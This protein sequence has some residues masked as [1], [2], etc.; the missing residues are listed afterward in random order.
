MTPPIFLE[1]YLMKV[2]FTRYYF[3]YKVQFVSEMMIIK[4]ITINKIRLNKVTLERNKC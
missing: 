1:T 4:K 3:L 2:L